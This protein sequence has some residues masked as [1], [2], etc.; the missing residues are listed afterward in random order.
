VARRALVDDPVTARSDLLF[1]AFGWY[2][3]WYFYRHFHA[4]RVS[5]AGLPTL[6][7]DRPLII[8]T[9]HPSW[10]DPALF[11]LVSRTLLRGRPGFGP[12]EQQALEKYGL[13]RRFGVFGIDT[14]SQ[15]GAARFLDVSLHVLSNPAHVLWITAEGHFT[16]ARQR[17]IRLQPGLAHLARRVPNAILLPMAIEYPFW[18]E[19]HPEALLRFG[20]PLM[21]GRHRSVADWTEMLQDGLKQTMDGLAQDSQA[22]DPSLFRAL[23]QRGGGVG[24][25][26]DLWR[27]G[28]AAAAGRSF[29]PGHESPADRGA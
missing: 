17:P 26:Y 24:G 16:D 12:M 19:R 5:R 13:F 4:V 3:R 25:I 7:P 18:N 20:Q 29:D 14:T 28:R 21:A 6:P 1:R 15:R 10:W 8:Y 2:L 27:R 9:N 22:R 23:V 11:I